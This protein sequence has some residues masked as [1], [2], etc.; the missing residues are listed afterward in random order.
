MMNRLGFSA[1]SLAL[2]LAGS[3]PLQARVPGGPGVGCRRAFA[4]RDRRRVRARRSV[5]M[6]GLQTAD[7]RMFENVDC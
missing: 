3:A 2:L 4:P 5:L 1:T 6:T 7:N